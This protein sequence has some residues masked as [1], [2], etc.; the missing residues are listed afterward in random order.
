MKPSKFRFGAVLSV[1]LF[2][3]MGV[4]APTA[5]AIVGGERADNRGIAAILLDD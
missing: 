4:M 2:V 1:L 3:S 5:Q